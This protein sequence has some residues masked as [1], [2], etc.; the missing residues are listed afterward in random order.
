MGTGNLKRLAGSYA[1]AY[2]L[3][4]LPVCPALEGI[5]GAPLV[6]LAAPCDFIALDQVAAL[7]T[8]RYAKV[9]WIRLEA[10][11]AD[12]GSLL[13]AL[14]DAL[15]LS[16]A[17]GADA[18]GEAVARWGRRGE[19]WHVYRLLG[20][21]LGA[22][23]AAPA[24]MVLEGAEHLEK[25]SPSILDLLVSALFPAL[26]GNV[27]ILFIGFTKWNSRRLDAHGQVLGPRQ[28]R[29]DQRSA[30]LAAEVLCF[31]PPTEAFAR[32]FALARGAAAAL[33]AAYSAGAVLGPEAFA[34]AVAGAKSAPE[35]LEGLCRSLLA[36]SNEDTL[37]ALAGATRLGV[38][39]PGIGIALGN[40]APRWDGPWWLDLS[41]GWR[42][43]MPT[44]RGPLQS[45]GGGA[46]FGLSSLTHLAHYLARQ[47]MGVRAFELFL[48]AGE[49]DCAIDTAVSLMGELAN[50]G[51]WATISQLGHALGDRRE[52]FERS[53][54]LHDFARPPSWRK[55]WRR[56]SRNPS[57]A[58]SL[59]AGPILEL[60]PP[61]LLREAADQ[62]VGPDLTSPKREVSPII[63]VHL[64]GELQ[65]AFGDSAVKAWASGRGRA[66]FEYLVVHRHNRVQRDRLM[67]KFW[68]GS[69]PEAARN[70][71]NVAIHGLRRTLRTVAGDRTIVIHQD[72][73]Y[74]IDPA[75]DV[76]VD[77]EIFED[78]LKSAHQHLIREEPTRAEADFEAAIELYGGEFLADDPYEE[79][80]LVTR[81]HLRLSYLDC[82]DQL[83]RLRFN[84][85]DYSGCIEVCS[86][87]LA[88]DNC[89]EDAHRRLMRS[90]SRQGQ[91]QLALRQYHTCAAIL[92]RELRL[93]PAPATTELFGRIRQRQ[94]V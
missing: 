33:G 25:G 70:S 81:E 94:K 20:D 11:D 31:D 61:R 13:L 58:Q 91:L 87:I 52:G 62:T 53:F 37:T 76:W 14:T 67:S 71:L 3:Q 47:G 82:L 56:L 72:G 40:G 88:C 2:P 18:I 35:L 17:T 34:L 51:C 15:A 68:P 54:E 65:V 89:R 79:W 90:Y 19:W 5:V 6:A 74:F 48:D 86:K 93:S 41:D 1:V 12:P 26:Q 42:Q 45:A 27:D 75:L 24:I 85:G 59:D 69:S 7:I 39:H 46:S 21:V 78:R 36:R 57:P 60:A 84:S 38:W 73:A 64:L 30:A 8:E 22:A 66:V 80:A 44:W 43:L 83:S 77:V 9:I 10:A 4:A 55:W 28:L 29:L 49:L 16:Y 50:A 92:S 23:A 63:T 32:S